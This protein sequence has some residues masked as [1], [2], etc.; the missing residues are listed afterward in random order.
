MIY[1]AIHA[2]EFVAPGR[3]GDVLNLYRWQ[4]LPTWGVAYWLVIPLTSIVSPFAAASAI[5]RTGSIRP[6]SRMRRCSATIVVFIGL[7][8]NHQQS[9]RAS[10]GTSPSR[11]RS[12][13]P[14]G[15]SQFGGFD[16]HHQIGMIAVTNERWLVSCP[17]FSYTPGSG[18]AMRAAAGNPASAFVWSEIR[19]GWMCQSRLGHGIGDW[20]PAM[21]S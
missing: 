5:E 19:V 11:P 3:N 10:S 14:S 20:A 21:V 9:R 4:M 12:E 17:V 8:C 6:P 1:Q 18:L 16:Q 15:G 2:S 13:A 7:F